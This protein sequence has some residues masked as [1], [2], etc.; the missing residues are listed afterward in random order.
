M[1]FE[2]EWET[3]ASAVDKEWFEDLFLS[4]YG[5]SSYQGKQVYEWAE[6]IYIYANTYSSQTFFFLNWCA[7]KPS[8]NLYK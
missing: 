2:E 6:Y 3:M 5:A 1:A 8:F 7:N 4:V